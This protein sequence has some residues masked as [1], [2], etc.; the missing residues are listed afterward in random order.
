MPEGACK[1][2]SKKGLAGPKF[3]VE[4]H[5]CFVVVAVVVVVVLAFV[6]TKM[7]VV[8]VVVFVVA[9]VQSQW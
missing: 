8:V 4:K 9:V 5:Q 2:G 1:E 6:V 7:L 3:M